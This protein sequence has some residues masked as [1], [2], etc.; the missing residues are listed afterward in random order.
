MNYADTWN[1]Q[2]EAKTEGTENAVELEF[3]GLKGLFRRLSLAGWAKT[4]RLPYFVIE[5]LQK[6]AADGKDVAPALVSKEDFDKGI[7]YQKSIVTAVTAEPKIVDHDGPLNPGEVRY[8]DL[9]FMFPDAVDQ[10]VAWVMS[11]S[12][13]V[14]VRMTDGTKASLTE[15]GNFRNRKQRRTASATRNKVSKVRRKAS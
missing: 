7:E 6:A 12:P 4:G 5:M 3:A 10:I 13:E 2:I 8:N 9:A 1:R 15:V 11:G 14:P